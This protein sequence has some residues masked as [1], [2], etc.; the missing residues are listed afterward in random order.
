MAGETTK[1]A[2]LAVETQRGAATRASV[3]EARRL[4]QSAARAA[5]RIAFFV[6]SFIVSAALAELSI[7]WLLPVQNVGPSFSTYDPS[8]YRVLKKNLRCVRYSPEFTMHLSTNSLGLR[9]PEPPSPPN[10]CILFLG[11]SQTMG[12]G[13]D[14]GQEYPSLLGKMLNDRYGAGQ[15]AVLNTAVG[16]MGNG[17]WI[18]LLGGDVWGYRPR[19]VVL[20][21]SSTDEGD[22]ANEAMFELSPSGDLL[23]R[24]T[25]PAGLGFYLDRAADSVPFLAYSYFLGLLKQAMASTHVGTFMPSA[26]TSAPTGALTLKLLDESVAICRRRGWPVI[27]LATDFTAGPL[28]DVR[29]LCS[30]LNVPLIVAPTKSER[31]ELFFAIDPHWNALGQRHIASLLE[32]SILGD[33]KPLGL[34][35]QPVSASID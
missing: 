1:I 13:V 9:G 2:E 30:R 23:E 25:P 6:T 18:K 21:F 8:L 15:I 27:V 34:G 3:R 11:D 22:N 17:R 35:G 29:R 20:Q 16:G 33:R 28:A 4:P 14:D 24:P 7:R 32:Q 19:L 12:H 10:E 5:A 31:P 26:A